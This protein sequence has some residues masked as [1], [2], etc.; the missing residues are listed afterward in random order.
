L[1]GNVNDDLNRTVLSSRRKTVSEGALQ[2]EG[3]I[4]VPGSYYG[5]FVLAAGH[6]VNL[7]LVCKVDSPM[8]PCENL[9]LQSFTE[10]ACVA[11][12]FLFPEQRTK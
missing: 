12:Y 3:G 4:G 8:S 10:L 2:T 6:V 9:F 1:R 11:I 7:L 5:A